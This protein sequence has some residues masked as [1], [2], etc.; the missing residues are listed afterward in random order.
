MSLDKGFIF[1]PCVK[2]CESIL[3]QQCSELHAQ[4]DNANVPVFRKHD[5]LPRHTDGIMLF[6]RLARIC[7]SGRQIKDLT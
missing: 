2:L 7:S 4:N 3:T 1:L 6:V 5:T